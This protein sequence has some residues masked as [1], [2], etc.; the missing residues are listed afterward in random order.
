M[1]SSA[2]M[3]SFSAI[4]KINSIKLVSKTTGGKYRRMRIGRDIKHDQNPIVDSGYHR[5]EKSKFGT[6][7]LALILQREIERQVFTDI[8]KENL[9][10]AFIHKDKLWDDDR[11]KS[12]IE[13]DY[14][15]TVDG[16]LMVKAGRDL[17]L[18]F[19]LG[20]DEKIA[21]RDIK[22]GSRVCV[23]VVDEG[24]Y[25]GDETWGPRF[26]VRRITVT[27]EGNGSTRIEDGELEL[28]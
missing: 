23:E 24:L 11:S 13:S 1:P 10:Y 16:R 3:P 27:E 28:L 19:N 7:T 15:A 2:T 18:C 6:A 22:P 14:K 26:K 8:D 4:Q 25:F 21:L 9:Q 12:D 20:D 17:E 5:V